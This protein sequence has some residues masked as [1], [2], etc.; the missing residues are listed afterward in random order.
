MR[1]VDQV[2]VGRLVLHEHDVL[3]EARLARDVDVGVE[4]VDDR[5]AR[6]RVRPLCTG[7]LDDER[8]EQ[9]VR[10]RT[11][12]AATGIGE[13]VEEEHALGG[14]LPD[15]VPLP[16][17]RGGRVRVAADRAAVRDVH[18]VADALRVDA[19]RPVELVA[20][21]DDHLVADV[22]PQNERP[23]QRVRL[24]H[25]LGMVDRVRERVRPS[26]LDLAQCRLVLGERE[27]HP[28]AV[29]VAVR[30]VGDRYPE[31]DD[32]ERTDTHVNPQRFPSRSDPN[33]SDRPPS[34]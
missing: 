11:L 12:L 31:R 21:V 4:P 17:R 14:A 7:G 8:A 22:R 29:V 5:V 1:R 30:V 2:V 10:V 26:R 34:R 28:V 24:R 27:D 6:A 15:V 18:V 20:E 25:Q 32:A 16:A 23:D 3:A 9:A 33:R 19:C 13:V